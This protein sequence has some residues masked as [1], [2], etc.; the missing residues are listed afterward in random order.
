MK[1]LIISILLFSFALLAGAQQYEYK[2]NVRTGKPDMVTKVTPIDLSN[3]V[4]NNTLSSYAT[5]TALSYYMPLTLTDSKEVNIDWYELNIKHQRGIFNISRYGTLLY[6][7]RTSRTVLLGNDGTNNEPYELIKLSYDSSNNANS[8]Y[9]TPMFIRCMR[10]NANVFTVS[11]IGEVKALNFTANGIAGLT[12]TR[13]FNEQSV[14]NLQYRVNTV[15][16]TGG[17]ITAWTQGTW[18]NH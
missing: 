5:N 4:T 7:S 6:N 12:A 17:I 3:Y 11:G 9:G 1:K 14:N 10:D 13:T 18:T 15:T 2:T 8:I 16:I